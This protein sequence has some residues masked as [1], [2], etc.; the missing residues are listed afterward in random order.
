MK[1]E[2][3]QK[4]VEEKMCVCDTT[5]D[6]FHCHK[7]SKTI[8]QI[9]ANPGYRIYWQEMAEKMNIAFEL[10]SNALE[11]EDKRICLPVEGE[12]EKINSLFE[13]DVKNIAQDLVLNEE[14]KLCVDLRIEENLAII[15]TALLMKNISVRL[16]KGCLHGAIESIK[17][18]FAQ[19]LYEN[20]P[21]HKNMHSGFMDADHYRSSSKKAS[22]FIGTMHNCPVYGVFK[23]LGFFEELKEFCVLCENHGKSM[24]LPFRARME[25]TKSIS[26]GDKYCE[27][28]I[29]I[30]S[31]FA[32]LVFGILPDSIFFKRRR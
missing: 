5:F 1:K 21:R 20:F 30:E 16:R 4:S 31:L 22:S 29:S 9:A 3:F 17:E 11:E 6:L 18:K 23:Y 12:A 19:R 15:K 28:R 13:E 26:F 25:L 27:F 8:H 7:W 14:Q 32:K 10:L 2:I 24:R